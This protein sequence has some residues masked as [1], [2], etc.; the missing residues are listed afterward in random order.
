MHNAEGFAKSCA[1][2]GR[3]LRPIHRHDTAS[4]PWATTIR[5][6]ELLLLHG[7]AVRGF[8]PLVFAG[9]Q[10][11]H[12]QSHRDVHGRH[13]PGA[14]Q[15]SRQQRPPAAPQYPNIFQE[16]D[17]PNVSWKIYYTVPTADASRTA[18]LL[19]RR[20][21][22]PGHD[23]HISAYSNQYVYENPAERPVP[24]PPSPRA[25]W[26]TRPTPSA[27]IPTT[28]LRCSTYFTDVANG[29]LPSFAFIEAGYGLN[30]EHPGSGQ[31]VLTAR[32]Q[33]AKIV[34]AL[35]TSPS[36]KNSVFFFSYDEG[37][38]PYDHVPPVPGHSNDITDTFAWNS[39][40]DISSI[41]VNP[42]AYNPCVPPTRRNADASL[43][44]V[45]NDPGAVRPMRR[46]CRALQRNSVSA[47]RNRD[48][49]VHPEALRLAHPHGPHGGHQVRG[50]PVH[51]HSAH[52]H[53][54]R[55]RAA[56]PA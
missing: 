46:P 54:P 48:L 43:R 37:G 8:R 6:S 42:D 24:R 28:S 1:Q 16:L 25:W 10:Q 5:V 4:A 2:V 34:N 19:R 15:R 18:I 33:V 32:L 13:H 51:R 41:A 56:E 55:C 14:G 12:S 39:I 38:G 49:A 35:T 21:R 26:V 45:S 47:C 50:E 30:D 40:P 27:S 29:T 52:P 23:F 53:G 22:L 20:P 31:S 36:W 44:P 9:G 11:E 3:L 7:F 17:Q